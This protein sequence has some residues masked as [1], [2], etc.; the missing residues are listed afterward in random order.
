MKKEKKNQDFGR[1]KAQMKQI[2]LLE[3]RTRLTHTN[4]G[5]S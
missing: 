5:E 2:D 1:R 4:S 3:A